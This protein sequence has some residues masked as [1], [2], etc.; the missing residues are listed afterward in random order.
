MDRELLQFSVVL[1]QL[2]TTPWEL[3][4]VAIFSMIQTTLTL[5]TVFQ[6]QRASGKQVEKNS[7]KHPCTLSETQLKQ[8][9]HLQ[10]IC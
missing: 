6:L 10:T 2:D 3:E 7:E 8:P 9:R 4:N 5:S 1:L